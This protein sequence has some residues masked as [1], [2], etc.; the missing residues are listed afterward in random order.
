MLRKK[1][2]KTAN[3]EI[4]RDM[5][6]DGN[7]PICNI[8]SQFFFFFVCLFVFVFVFLFCFVFL[9]LVTKFKKVIIVNYAKLSVK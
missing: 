3:Y 1:R 9:K 4:S 2:K 6:I 7:Y 8:N 5:D